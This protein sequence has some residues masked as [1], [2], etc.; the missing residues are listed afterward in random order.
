MCIF[1]GVSLTCRTWGWVLCSSSST[2]AAL[3][4]ADREYVALRVGPQRSVLDALGLTYD[5][6]RKLFEAF[7]KMDLAGG[8][9]SSGSVDFN[10]FCR[11]LDVDATP[12]AKKCFSMLDRDSNGRLSFGEFVVCSY[13]LCSYN[14]KGLGACYIGCNA[15]RE[16][17]MA[18]E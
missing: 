4:A 7:E 8:G 16:G 12:F 11:F 10:E 3:A 15:R 13:C 17:A 14:R 9:K 1:P 6:G 18:S 5:D 2:V